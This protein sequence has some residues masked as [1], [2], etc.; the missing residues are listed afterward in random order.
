[1]PESEVAPS[2]GIAHETPADPVEYDRGALEASTASALADIFKDGDEELDDAPPARKAPPK[3]EAA[4]EPEEK[5]EEVEQEAPKEA[6]AKQ[7]EKPAEP[8]PATFTGVPAQ[9][10]RS[11]KANGWDDAEIN[12]AY[13]AN[14]EGFTKIAERTHASR[15]AE[16]QRWAEIGKAAKA[17]ANAPEPEKEPSKFDVKALR[18]KYGN[19][20][21]IDALEAVAVENARN[22]DFVKASKERQA[23]AELASLT[24][25]VDKFFSDLTPYHDHYGKSGQ[26]LSDKHLAERQ[27]VLETADLLISGARQMGRPMTLDEALTMAHDSVSSPI[28]EKAAVKK[29]EAAIRTRQQAISLRPGSRA[30]APAAAGRKELESKVKTGLAS[31]FK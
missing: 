28:R 20:P 7:V 18:A 19:E 29:V 12:A 10:R 6:A 11:L 21:F 30:A 15:V 23:Q 22:R 9:H 14:P 13:T 24:Q 31:I 2:S 27:K 17:A 5:P 25:N 16:T 8:T 26:Q 1:M 4:K 3:E